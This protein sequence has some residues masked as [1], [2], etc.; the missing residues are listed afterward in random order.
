MY[1]CFRRG[2]DKTPI[3]GFDIVTSE[4]EKGEVITKTPY[5]RSANINN[6]SGFGA[7]PLYLR[8]KRDA[9]ALLVLTEIAVV[10][11]NKVSSTVPL[12]II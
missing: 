10:I 8:I 12:R 9:H 6:G 3:V 4:D 7:V 2:K 1:L 11:P 5:S